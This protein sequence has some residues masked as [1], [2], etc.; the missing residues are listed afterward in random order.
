MTNRIELGAQLTFLGAWITSLNFG[1]CTFVLISIDLFKTHRTH[2]YQQTPGTAEPLKKKM[3]NMRQQMG[4]AEPLLASPASL[5]RRCFGSRESPRGE[6]PVAPRALQLSEGHV[7][8]R[9]LQLHIPLCILV[10]ALRFRLPA[11][12]IRGPP[13]TPTKPGKRSMIRAR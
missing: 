7:C 12:T 3:S 4:I 13:G 11:P 2:Q 9:A 5:L 6:G 10:V 1:G 8:K